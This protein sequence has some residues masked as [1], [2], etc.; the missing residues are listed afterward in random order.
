MQLEDG[1][2]DVPPG[3]L[4]AVVTHLE[5]R[6]KAPL[7]PVAEPRGPGLERIQAPGVDWYRALFR[8]VGAEDW[9][10]FSR[11]VMDE[12]ALQAILRDPLVEVYA[13][14][15][16]GADKGL[17]ELDFREEGECELAFF[18]L[19]SDLIGR[20][21]GRWLMNRAID[22]AWRRGITRFHVHT[23]TLDSPQALSFYM[24]SGFVPV[25]RQ[26]EIADDPRLAG[27][28]PESAA[29]QVPILR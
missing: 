23:C 2:Y 11:L 10:W 4:A 29:P 15:E 8:K 6:A 26:V 9:L 19:A 18:G 22:L 17:L 1:F 7:R 25:R 14:R 27:L 13:L 3:K 24:R 20:G 5:M 12:A 16:G 28:L 21:V